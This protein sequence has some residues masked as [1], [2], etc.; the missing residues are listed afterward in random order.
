MSAAP[1]SPCVQLC[2][3]HRETGLCVG[4]LRTRDEIARWG[5]LSNHER[6]AIM[7]SLPER[8]G[9]LKLRRG[10]RKGRLARQ[11]E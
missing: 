5:G 6:R 3:I 8:E 9:R 7:E 2:A 10:G 4:C 1:L 11:A